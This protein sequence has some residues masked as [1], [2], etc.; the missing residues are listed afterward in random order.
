MS[1]GSVA[2]SSLGL[3]EWRCLGH[4]PHGTPGE[5]EPKGVGI[6][7]EG[8]QGWALGPLGL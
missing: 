8:H 7:H 4:P 2:A 3:P 1:V 6:C 5:S